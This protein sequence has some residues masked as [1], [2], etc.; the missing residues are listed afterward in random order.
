M[1]KENPLYITILETTTSIFLFLM[2]LV[3]MFGI[4]ARYV[5]ST[6]I[7]WTDELSRFLMFYVVLLGSA[8]AIRQNNHPSLTF[9]IDKF[10]KRM[11]EMW[12]VFLFLLIICVLL[13]I[14]IGGVEQVRDSFIKKTAALRISYSIVY[15]GFP[16]GGICMLVETLAK[17]FLKM[18]NLKKT[19][20]EI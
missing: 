9:V 3:V 4:F 13:V 18:K 14:I 15:L 1:E 20:E 7:F 12:D 10:P 19:K 17:I 16:V 11:R 2:F 8:L 6:P 5:I